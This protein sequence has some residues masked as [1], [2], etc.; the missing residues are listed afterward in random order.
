M[1]LAQAKAL[2]PGQSVCTDVGPK[3]MR[4]KING[5]PKTWKRDPSRV[6]VPVKYG[7]YRYDRF[8]E[9]DTHIFYPC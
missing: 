7:L 5:K 1:T 4:W 2:K 6:E 3:T 9:L 8:T